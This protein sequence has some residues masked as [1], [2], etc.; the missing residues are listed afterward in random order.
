M[1][2]ARLVETLPAINW[3]KTVGSLERQHPPWILKG[4]SADLIQLPKLVLSECEFDCREIV[5]KLAKSFRAYDARGYH[6]L[7]QEPRER[8]T[9]S[10]TSSVFRDW[11]YY[12]E[13]IPGPLFV[14]DG[15]IVFTAARIRGVLVGPTELAGKQAAGK[16]TPHEQADLFGFQQRSDFPFQIAAG[17]RVIGLKRVE[18]GQVPELG[19]AEG[20]GDLPCLP[21]GAADVANLSLLHQGVESAKRLF[22]RSDGIVA[23]D[24]VQIDMVGLQT[25][26]TGLHTVHNVASR[27]P[28]FIPA[29]ADAAIVLRRDHNILPCDVKV[30]QRLPEN[31][32]ALTLRVIVRRIKEVDAAVNRSLDQFIGPGLANGADGLEETS[33]VPEC[34]G[35]EAEL[36][37]QE[38]C[39]AERCVL[40]GVFL[41]CGAE[42]SLAGRCRSLVWARLP[43][44]LARIV[45]LVGSAWPLRRRCRHREGSPGEL[46]AEAGSFE[47]GSSHDRSLLSI[48]P[49]F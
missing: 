11:S 25:A 9:C 23:V 1:R 32:F 22:D 19:D 44:E 34:H 18:S 37:N 8:N 14:H 45:D 24:L 29:R 31:L 21:V 26:K 42:V 49:Y 36:R 6:R 2:L 46:R 5:P 39:I 10:T 33:A 43:F 7:C 41:S 35:S 3:L 47:F 17:D 27:S 16:R 12:V 4:K 20:F 48:R 30:F 13:D 38:T 15:K 40:H 28:E